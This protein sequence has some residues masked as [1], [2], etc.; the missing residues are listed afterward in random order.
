MSNRCQCVTLC[1]SLPVAYS[2]TYTTVPLHTLA[3]SAFFTSTLRSCPSWFCSLVLL[4]YL[5]QVLP[6]LVGLAL[7]FILHGTN[8]ALMRGIRSSC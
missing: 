1:S 7:P 2:T 4:Q 5:A 3:S 6:F 8:R